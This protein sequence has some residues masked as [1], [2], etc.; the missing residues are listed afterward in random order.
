[1]ARVALTPQDIVI[2]GL[3]ATYSS[4]DATNDHSVANGRG[5]V[6]VHVVNGGGGAIN[7]TVPTP[8]TAVQG[9]TIE[10]PVIN[11]PAGEDR[12]IGPF[13]LGN[14]NQ[15]DGSGIY[16]DL[17]SDTSVTIAAIRLPRFN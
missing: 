7:V 16:V 5:D 10:D 17:D 9:L 15:S 13:D 6:F 12:F 8:S 1:M 3:E 14:F 4:A 2:S 11:V